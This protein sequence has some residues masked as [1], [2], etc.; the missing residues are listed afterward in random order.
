M[1]PTLPVHLERLAGVFEQSGKDFYIVGGALRDQL[2][3]RTHHEWDVATNAKPDEIIKLLQKGGCQKINLVG[4]RFGTIAGEFHNEPIEITTYRTEQYQEDSRKPAVLFGDNLSDDLSRRD[5][6][7]NAL[8]YSPTEKKLIDSHDGQQDLQLKQIRSVGN[9]VERF[10]E[11]PLRMLRAIRLATQLGFSIERKTFLAI[12]GEKDRFGVLSAERVRQEIDKILLSPTP[13]QGIELLKE[14]GLI[15]YILPE[16]LPS[17]DIEFDP[18]EHKDIYHHIIQVLD[19][20]PPQL[21]LRWCA[22]LHDIAKPITRKKIGGEYH[23]LGHEIV[24]AR[25]AKDVLGRLKYSTDF[26]KYVTKL[27]RLHQRIPN[28]D[29]QWT[30]GAVR[31]FVRDAGECLEDLFTFAEAD[32]TGKNERKLEQYRQKR[33]ELKSRIAELEKLA[34]IAK[35]K[36]PLSGEELME[37][38]HRPAGPWIKPV[39]EELLRQV[40]EG[41]L[42]QDDKKKAAEI[43]RRLVK[44]V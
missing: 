41:D 3:G 6:T 30:D 29:G 43:A 26:T 23:F 14:S 15:A 28:D 40:I 16:L 44:K 25:M 1:I 34:E 35:I 18:R 24:G 12:I 38:F 7:I 4:K 9:A 17:I 5:F 8:A 39:K 2:L 32:S 31:R 37:L 13:S 10:H 36:S 27:V 33:Q 19:N 22:L 11:D 42:K 21:A 20:T